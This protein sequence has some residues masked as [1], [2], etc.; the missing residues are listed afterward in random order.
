MIIVEDHDGQKIEDIQKY[1][2]DI[3]TVGSDG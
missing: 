1:G 2:A 3:F